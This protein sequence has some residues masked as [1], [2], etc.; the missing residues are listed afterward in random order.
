MLV[1]LSLSLYW[2][3]LQGWAVLWMKQ[4]CISAENDWCLL[5]RNKRALVC[6][7]V[8]F[9]MRLDDF[10]LWA[11]HFFRVSVVFR[12]GFMSWTHSLRFTVASETVPPL[13]FLSFGIVTIWNC[14]SQNHQV[15]VYICFRLCKKEVKKSDVWILKTILNVNYFKL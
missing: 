15:I 10:L 6:G 11:C 7:T 8:A 14:R 9:G 5:P 1:S 12:S 13:L 4:R 2:V 3:S